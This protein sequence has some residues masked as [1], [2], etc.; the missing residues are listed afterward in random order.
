MAAQAGRLLI[1]CAA[2]GAVALSGC[3]VEATQPRKFSTYL[4]DPHTKLQPP[5]FVNALIPEA[6]GSFLLT[7]NRGFW[8]VRKGEKPQKLRGVVKDKAG[9][10]PVGTFLEVDRVGPHELV[11]SGHPDDASKLPPYLGYIR[12]TDNGKTWRIVSRLGEAD[13]HQIRRLNGKIFAFDAVLGAILVSTDDGKTWSERFTPRQLILDFVVDP[14]D[15]KHMIA[16]SADTLYRSTDGGNGWRPVDQVPAA[17]MAW[18]PGGDTVIRADKDG[19]FWVS[20]DG[21]DTWQQRGKIDGEPYKVVAKSADDVY[22]ALSD[23]TIL[24]TKDGGR[25]FEDRFRP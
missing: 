1:A 25:S 18:P 22:V 17:R 2:A 3:G 8:R 14:K 9:T 10:A 16:S 21:G 23:G 5:I 7:T 11:G 24:E 12:S 13:L 6:D 4:V 19:T 20:E 15:E